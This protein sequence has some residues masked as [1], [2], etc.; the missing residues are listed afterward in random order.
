MLR[1]GW[2]GGKSEFAGWVRRT[3]GAPRD[4]NRIPNYGIPPFPRFFQI[5]NSQP[6]AS[7]GKISQYAIIT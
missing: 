7:L 1:I 6:P 2:K 4:G 5:R 3:S